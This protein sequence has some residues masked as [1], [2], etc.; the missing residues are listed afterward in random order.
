MSEYRI[1]GIKDFDLEHTF[2]CGQCFRWEKQPDDSYT[3]IAMGK[4]VNMSFDSEKGILIIDNCSE[5]DFNNIWKHYLDFDTDYSEIKRILS[6]ED[7]VMKKAIEYGS[8]IRILNQELWETVLSF[9][10]SQNNNIPRI[11]GCIENLAKSFGTSAG[12]YKGREYYNLPSAQV[13]S[14]LTVEDLASVRLG[15]R[16]K[17]IIETSKCVAESGL[18]EDAQELTNLC[19]V[20]PKVANC[21]ALFGMNK[22]DSFPI[23]VWVRRVMSRL[24]GLDEDNKKEI[25]SFAMEKFGKLSGFAQQYLFYYMRKNS[26]NIDKHPQ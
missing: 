13:L 21:I 14:M 12:Y 26:E 8:G 4:V 1:E 16:A 24:Y 9:L 20:G 25:A 10:I 17:Y 15:Y 19:G 3:G 2:D 5:D 23:D 18:P 11:K 6:L 22:C 7:P